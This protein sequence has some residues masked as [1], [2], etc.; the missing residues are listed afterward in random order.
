MASVA[1]G[2]SRAPRSA[3]DTFLPTARHLLLRQEESAPGHFG[4]RENLSSARTEGI[5]TDSSVVVMKDL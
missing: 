1:L 3:E 4:E 2:H 5:G